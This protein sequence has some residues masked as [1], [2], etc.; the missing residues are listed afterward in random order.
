MRHGLLS[1]LHLLGYDIFLSGDD[2]R[3]RYRK[4]DNPPVSA[5]LLI[6]ELAKYKL[7]VVTLLKAYDRTNSFPKKSDW[8]FIEV[9]P[10]P[11]D[12]FHQFNETQLERL[13]IMTVDGGLSD[14]D[15]IAMI[16]PPVKA[17]AKELWPPEVQ[18]LINWFQIQAPPAES[19]YLEPH[20]RV[21]DPSK[22]FDALRH[23]I[24]AGPTGPRARMGT[25]Q[26]DLRK[27]KAYLN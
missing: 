12:W 15:A 25:L 4:P 24:K 20:M 1:D 5:S 17:N 8:E 21:L 11:S 18:A 7:D 13:A 9:K 3:Y 23:E 27:L 19:F 14:E 10:F 6:N 22:F 2:I 16:P 26:S